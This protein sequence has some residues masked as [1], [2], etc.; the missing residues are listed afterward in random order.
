QGGEYRAT[1][2]IGDKVRLPV[3]KT[4]LKLPIRCR[5]EVIRPAVKAL[6]ECIIATKNKRDVVQQI[7]H[8]R[9]AGHGQ[10]NNRLAAAIDHSVRTIKGN[11]KQAS[12][13]PLELDLLFFVVTRPD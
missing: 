10:E 7:D 8:Q 1:A 2:V 12:L 9:R 3:K 13:L 6:I 5:H 11:R 4:S